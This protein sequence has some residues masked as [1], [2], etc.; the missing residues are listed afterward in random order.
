MRN[1]YYMEHS[2]DWIL[3]NGELKEELYYHDFLHLVERGNMQFANSILKMLNTVKSTSSILPPSSS[4]LSPPPS[5][6]ASRAVVSPSQT[7]AHVKISPKDE[8][9]EFNKIEEEL[10]SQCHLHGVHYVQPIRKEKIA[11]LSTKI[12]RNS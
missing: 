11:Q 4:S 3:E 10:K 2:E 9:H 1:V 8:I 7:K 6:V 5:V 12:T